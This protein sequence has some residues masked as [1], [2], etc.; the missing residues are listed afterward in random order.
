M[1]KIGLIVSYLLLFMTLVSCNSIY[2]VYN[3]EELD[4][5]AINQY[6][7]SEVLFFKVIDQ[8]TAEEL[9]GEKYVNSGV[10][11][12]IQNGTYSMLFVPRLLS[13]EPFM[14]VNHFDFNIE[15]MY[16]CLEALED[17]SG[18]PLFN[19]PSGDFGGLSMSVSP[20]QSIKDTNPLLDFDSRVIFIVTTDTEVFYLAYV[21][22]ICCIFNDDF[23]IY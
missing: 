10:V 15:E 4:L 8:D 11:V 3:D 2:R 13:K 16:D 21:E 7:F 6:S 22:G 9:T 19:D 17:A 23:E 20:Y 14:I 18:N 5:L 12:G 1:K